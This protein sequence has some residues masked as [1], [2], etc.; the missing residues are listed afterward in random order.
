M[1]QSHKIHVIANQSADW[2]GNPFS[3]SCQST[4]LSGGVMPPPY[5]ASV[6]TSLFLLYIPIKFG[7]LNWFERNN[8]RFG[9]FY[10][11]PLSPIAPPVF[12]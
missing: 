5:K 12:L 10:A 9:G 4:Q 11:I 3:F 2:C 1:P 6:K 8:D 7:K